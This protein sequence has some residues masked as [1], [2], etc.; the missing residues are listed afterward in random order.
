[1]TCSSC[2]AEQP[3]GARFCNQC[4]TTLTLVCAACGAQLPPGSRFCNACGTPTAAG[5]ATTGAGGHA[6]EPPDVGAADRPGS[7]QRR[8]T[9]V[10]FCDLV[11]FTTIA[12]ARDHEET[13]ELLSRYFDD[14]QAIVAQYGGTVEKF[15]GDAVMA[16]W[17]VP[18]AHEDDAERAVRAGLELV[19]RI[20]DMGGDLGVADLA[21]RVGIV[22]GEVAT[23]VGAVNQGMVAGDAVNTASRVQSVAGPGQVW[24]DETTRLLSSGAITYVDAGSHLLKGKAEPVPLWS[25]RAVVAARGGAQRADG[26]EAPLVG[27]DRELRL[28]KE[29]FHGVQTGPRPALLLVDGEAGVGKTRLAWE[30]EKYSDGLEGMVH[31][32]TGR[33][34]AY[35][36][37]VAFWAI[38]EAVRGRLAAVADL[39][40]LAEDG[41]GTDELLDATFDHYGVTVDEREW[42]RPR[43]EVLLGVAAHRFAKEDLFAAWTS[44]FD[45]IGGDGDP[46]I[47]V[48]DDAQHAEDGLLEFVEHLMTWATFPLFVMMMTRPGLLERRV[49]LATHGNSTVIHLGAL[50]ER[51]MGALLDGLVAGLPDDT[52]ESLVERAEGIPL[53]AVETVRSL[54]DRDLVV[55]RGGVYVLHTD[56]PLDLATIAAPA[57]LQALVSARLDTLTADQRHVVDVASVLGTTLSRDRIADLC[58]D[59][60]DIDAVLAQLVHQQILE[61]QQSRLSSEFGRYSFRQSVVRQVAYATLSLRDR[62]RIHLAVIA[63]YGPLDTTSSDQAA[64]LAQHHLDAIDAVPSD[65]DVPELRRAAIDLLLVAGRR[66]RTLG[67]LDEAVDHLRGALEQETD[68]TRGAHVRSELADALLDTTDWPEAEQVALEAATTLDRLD[69]EVAAASAWARYSMAL[70]RQQRFDE[71]EAV[72]WPLWERLRDDPAATRAALDL[73]TALLVRYGREEY[74]ERMLRVLDDQARLAEK[75]GDPAHLA[76]ATLAIALRY[77]DEG[78]ATLATTL[79]EATAR[80]SRE[81]QLPLQLARAL[82]NQCAYAVGGDAER[83]AEVG[84][85]AV[86]AGHRTGVLLWSSASAVNLALALWVRGDWEELGSL[87]DGGTRWAEGGDAACAVAVDVVLANATGEAARLDLELPTPDSLPMG[88]DK[89]WVHFARAGRLVL[90]GDREAALAEAVTATEVYGSVYDDYLHLWALATDLATDLGAREAG[91]ALLSAVDSVNA[92]V[93][94]GLLAHR[95]RFLARRADRDGAPAAEVEAGLREALELYERWGAL[96]FAA[97]ARGELGAWLVRQGRADEADPLLAAARSELEARGARPWLGELDRQLVGA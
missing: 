39:G 38:A 82:L 29:V 87:L 15:I 42:L 80:I 75:L 86:V 47:L 64:L 8:L 91:D 26:L 6:P 95:A 71:A 57:S 5:S 19:T 30:F 43:I 34:L 3:E 1:M 37:G 53:Y 96:A 44:F 90:R 69:D 59:V 62:K 7:A 50:D 56:D 27:R 49:S 97:R 81:H 73:A 76:D 9:S 11:G 41:L 18:T 22:T 68:D 36:E 61:H 25:A 28:V 46:V 13:R 92:A 45:R 51:S 17:G 78:V 85:E 24:V 40:G 72:A 23:T 33:C 94:P 83:A 70:S 10:L 67:L 14:A 16:V 74:D 31:W 63:S 12:E 88:F 58:P 35:G 77:M 2:H 55:P 89:A 48:I 93:P 32:H 66:A 52:R 21:G 84:R 79:I 65:D 4:G 54:I 20:G 60:D